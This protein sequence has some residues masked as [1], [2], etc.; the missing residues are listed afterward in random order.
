MEVQIGTIFGVGFGLEFTPHEVFEEMGDSDVKWGIIVD[1]FC[2][3]IVFLK[4]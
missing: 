4:L 2:I 3:R 1:L